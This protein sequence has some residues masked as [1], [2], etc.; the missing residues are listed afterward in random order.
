MQ[1]DFLCSMVEL[2]YEKT[3]VTGRKNIKNI[4]NTTREKLF[5]LESC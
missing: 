3:Y 4:S 1:I 5:F 2:F